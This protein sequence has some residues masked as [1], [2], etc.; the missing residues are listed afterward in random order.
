MLKL[1]KQNRYAR[2]VL[3]GRPDWSWPDGKRLAFYIATNVETFAFGTGVS[4][5]A[6]VLNAP[7]T[8]CNFAW[9][10]YGNRVAFWNLYD[11][12]DEFGIRTSCL[13][14]S[15]VFDE[16]PEIIERIQGRGD[17]IV[18][19]G[20]TNAETLRGLWEDD[21]R[22]LIAEATETIK[23]HTGKPPRGWLGPGAAETPV[24]P[25]LLKEAGY[26]YL[27]D[28]PCDDQP[29]W[30]ETRAGRLMS[31]PYPFELNDM[32]QILWRQH[33]AREFAHMVTDQFDELIRQSDD[34]PV[35]MC[36]S[37]HPY[38]I[39]QPFRLAALRRALKHI[40]SHPGFDKVWITNSDDI[41]D[42]CKTLEPG[43]IQ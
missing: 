40:T 36:V 25:D 38:L 17:A 18:G 20:R 2:S 26:E 29:V 4:P 35:V 5:D 31:V 12:L 11:L 10:D 34:H 1:P 30:I 19:H 21:E 7:P 9:R 32:G 13:V 39:G 41:Y 37:V 27:L 42:Y 23:A 16:Y 33:T 15:L 8:I 3:P 14:N 6:V 43:L 24:T 28:W 22:A